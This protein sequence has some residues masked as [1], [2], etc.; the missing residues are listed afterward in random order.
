MRIEPNAVQDN[1]QQNASSANKTVEDYGHIYF[2]L[3]RSGSMSSVQCDVIAGFNSYIQEQNTHNESDLEV[4]L[5]QFSNGMEVIFERKDIW[6]VDNLTTE[7]YVIGG[8]TQLYDTIGDT[9]RMAEKNKAADEQVIVVVMTDGEENGSGK[10]DKL[11]I[12]RLIAAKQEENWSFVF[13]GANQDSY[14]SG[15][16][17]G[18]LEENI[19]NWNF[20]GD[21]AQMAFKALSHASENMR[22]Q[23]AYRER[24]GKGGGSGRYRRSLDFNSK[25]F[26]Q[27]QKIAEGRPSVLMQSEASR[28]QKGGKGWRKY[29]KRYSRGSC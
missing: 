2:I 15:G 26:F 24:H 5:I 28:Q 22:S 3:D 23:L 7:T 27:G 16:S 19:Q 11:S 6:D 13:L 20:D 12:S 14:L 10:Y 1:T 17:F 29:S 8:G 25:N 4:T 21:G 18:L 9:I